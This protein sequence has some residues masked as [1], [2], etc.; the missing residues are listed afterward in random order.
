MSE[1][2]DCSDGLRRLGDG[3]VGSSVNFSSL[4]IKK[5]YIKVKKIR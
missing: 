4:K 2:F 1:I 5:I 3:S